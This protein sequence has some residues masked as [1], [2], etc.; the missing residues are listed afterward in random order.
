M[1]KSMYET[2]AEFITERV[3]YHGAHETGGIQQAAEDLCT[4]VKRL[5]ETFTEE[6][7]ILFRDCEMAYSYVDGETMRYFFKAGFGDAIHFL[8]DWGKRADQ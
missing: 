6:Q 5:Q 7:E 2:T 3:N 1:A 4:S 8:L